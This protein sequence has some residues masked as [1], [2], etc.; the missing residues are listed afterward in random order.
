MDGKG[1]GCEPLEKAKNNP[2]SMLCTTL[3]LF[4]Y[5]DK[6]EIWDDGEDEE[7]SGS[8]KYALNAS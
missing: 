5:G 7:I 2:R 3:L 4:K 1:I 6:N 8:L